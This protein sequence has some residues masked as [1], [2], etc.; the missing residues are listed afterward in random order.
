MTEL[1][2]EE[3]VELQEWANE[4]NLIGLWTGISWWIVAARDLRLPE[5]ASHKNYWLA[6][7]AAKE[8][9]E[10]EDE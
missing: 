10:D 7:K 5:I 1:T 9:L 2:A 6:L 8:R 4:H 3:K